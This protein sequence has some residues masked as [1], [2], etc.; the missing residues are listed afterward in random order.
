MKYVFVFS[1][2]LFFAG[3]QGR[4]SSTKKE[5]AMY[6]NEVETTIKTEIKD[7]YDNYEKSGLEWINYYQDHYTLIS[8]TGSVESETAKGLRKEWKEIYKNDRVVVI[9]HGEPTVMASEDMAVHWNPVSEA[10]ISKET[11]DTLRK[12]AGLWMAVWQKQ[13]DGSWKISV[14]TYQARD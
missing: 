11:G 4:E 5:E 8:P 9:S 7:M 1:V 12:S 13:D 10:F 14:E 3:C 6:H 2:L